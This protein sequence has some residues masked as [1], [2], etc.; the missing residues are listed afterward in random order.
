MNQSSMVFGGAC[1]NHAGN[2][3]PCTVGKQPKHRDAQD[4]R[5]FWNR[6]DCQA[7]TCGGY[8]TTGRH[9]LTVLS[10]FLVIRPQKTSLLTLR[11]GYS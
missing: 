5:T 2:S 4:G 3:P 10:S 7:R 6:F 1:S 8:T 11:L 9:Y